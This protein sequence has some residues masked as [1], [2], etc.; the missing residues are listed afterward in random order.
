MRPIVYCLVALCAQNAPVE[1]LRAN[2]DVQTYRLDLQVDPSAKTLK[3]T[4][5]VEATILVPTEVLELDLMAGRKVLAVNQITSPIKPNSSMNGKV[6][7]FTHVE[8]RIRITLPGRLNAG[9]DVRVAVT[10][11]FTPAAGR[12]GIRFGQTPDGKPWVTTSCQGLGAHSWW[13][14]KG[15]NEHPEDKFAHLYMN[16]RVP[17]GLTA[18]C[19]GKLTGR[20]VLP[21]KGGATWEE[22]RWRHDYPCENYSVSLDVA[23][24]VELSGQLKL[25]GMPKPLPYSYYV[26]PQD[27]EKAKLQF[28]DVPRMLEIYGEAFGPFPF[29]NS[30]FGLVQ[31]D[32]WGMEHSTAVAYGNSFPAWIKV[33]GGTDRWA[34]RNKYFDYILIHEVA[35]EWWGNAVS[36]KDWGHLWLHEGFATYAEG[37]YVEKT[38]GRAKADE[39]FATLRPRVLEKF[40]EFRGTGVLPNQAFDNNVYYK[41]ALILNTLRHYVDND[42]VWWKSLRE[43]NMRYRYKNATT[44]DFQ[45]VLDEVSG[46]SWKSFFEQWFYGDAYPALRGSVWAEGDRVVV[47]V[48]NPRIREVGFEV[49]LDLAWSIGSLQTKRRIMLQPGANKIEIPCPARAEGLRI[50]N[51]HR[52]LGD[53][54]VQVKGPSVH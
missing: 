47:E 28:Q 25:D 5:G 21:A 54:Q 27:L 35:H 8:D 24:Y 29:P 6:L 50:V 46:R 49:P 16:V 11:E 52:I 2:Y 12:S 19:T 42:A 53:N 31:T 43:F 14:Q 33:N 34:D 20:T 39:Y 38:M 4:V 26:L 15:E 10:Y 7:T 48:E 40:R 36:A 45:R 17:K 1:D 51:L 9:S 37:V 3:G 44:D 32:F 23:P 13:P 18:V 41:G 30:K 22:F